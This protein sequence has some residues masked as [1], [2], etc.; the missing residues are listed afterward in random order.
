MLVKSLWWLF[1]I[2]SLAIRGQ[3]IKLEDPVIGTVYTKADQEAV[4]SNLDESIHL[5][6]YF[7][8][9]FAKNTAIEHAAPCTLLLT[10]TIDRNGYSSLSRFS[11]NDPS[12]DLVP[13]KLVEC[14][15]RMPKWIPA[16]DRGKKVN[17]QV[18]L[19]LKT[20]GQTVSVRQLK[21]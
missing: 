3:S 15:E 6:Q 21:F 5:Q 14:I 11:A 7:I 8:N 13:Y 20:E 12:I 1:L 16:T 2:N 4:F 19:S 10:L 18:I 9:F 17:F